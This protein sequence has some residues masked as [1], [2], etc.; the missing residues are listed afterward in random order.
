VGA[1][2]AA[3]PSGTGKARSKFATV[4][5]KTRG[6]QGLAASAGS[7]GGSS[8]RADFQMIK[9]SVLSN[10]LF[11]HLDDEMLSKLVERMREGGFNLGGEQSGH[12][13]MTD[14]ATTGD[15]LVAGLQFLVEMARTGRQ[16]SELTRQFETVPQLLKNVRYAQGKQPLADPAVQAVGVP[17]G[18]GVMTAADLAL[19]YQAVLHNPGEMW[20]PDVI[21]DVRSNVRNRLP[22]VLSGVPA[23]R[24][25]GLVQAGDVVMYGDSAYAS[26]RLTELLDGRGVGTVVVQKA[27]RGRPLNETDRQENRLISQNR[28]R[29][30]HAFAVVSGSAGR[31]FHLFNL[32]YNLKRYETI[33]RLKLPPLAHALEP[34]RITWLVAKR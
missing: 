31:V 2:L 11:R 12:I 5:A 4:S 9:A 26:A 20:R 29:V 10:F 13:V 30:E 34:I 15:G 16:A 6:V 14:Y 3:P 21:T 32:C 25:L 19:Y 8:H 27:V 24:T 22:D 1:L 18:G 28:A 23:N 17:G 33:L 7:K